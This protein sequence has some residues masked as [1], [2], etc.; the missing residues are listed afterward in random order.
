MIEQMLPGDGPLGIRLRDVLNSKED[1]KPML[2]S[3]EK[4]QSPV[5]C[6]SED[7]ICS[8]A[9]FDS[10]ITTVTPEELHNLIQTVKTLTTTNEELE[11]TLSLQ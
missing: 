8:V 5:K 3:D 11:G 10:D 9:S 7:E 2:T 1:T 6:K 4:Q